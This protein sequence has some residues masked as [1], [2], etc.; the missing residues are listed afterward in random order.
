MAANAVHD[1]FVRAVRHKDSFTGSGSIEAW[2][3]RTVV[4]AARDS[5][6]G[7]A[8]QAHLAPSGEATAAS[9]NGHETDQEIRVLLRALPERQR[10]ALFLRY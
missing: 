6:H 10:L 8:K 3:W 4:N 1:A 7:E 9:T 5:R 2:L